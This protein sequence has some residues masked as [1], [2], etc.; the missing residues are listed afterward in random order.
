MR[1]WYHYIPNLK[2]KMVLD[3][4]YDSVSTMNSFITELP[5]EGGLDLNEALKKIAFLQ[6]DNDSQMFIDEQK[7]VDYIVIRIKSIETHLFDKGN[8]IKCEFDIFDHAKQ[9]VTVKYI[10]KNKCYD[11][12]G[13]GFPLKDHIHDPNMF[14]ISL[15]EFIRKKEEDM[16]YVVENLILSN[17]MITKIF[18]P[19]NKIIHNKTQYFDELK[20]LYDLYEHS[21][22]FNLNK[23][24]DD[25]F[26]FIKIMN[27]NQLYQLMCALYLHLKLEDFQLNKTKYES[28]STKAKALYTKVI[29]NVDGLRNHIYYVDAIKYRIHEKIIEN[30]SNEVLIIFNE[31]ND[32]ISDSLSKL[33]TY[34]HQ[35]EVQQPGVLPRGQALEQALEQQRLQIEQ[36][37]KLDQEQRLYEERER[38]ERI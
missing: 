18:L 35:L 29:F 8:D 25:F 12:Q 9:N 15:F 4:I 6:V 24:I 31:L 32:Y 30:P 34:L 1:I 19:V 2:E 27:V 16:F 37:V 11:M 22:T 20:E 3:T 23:N 36:R 38:L 21:T 7:K 17:G 14:C 10:K 28:L 33:R 13:L 26:D 5:K